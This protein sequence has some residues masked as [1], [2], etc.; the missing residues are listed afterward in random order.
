MRDKIVK[1]EDLQKNENEINI[2]EKEITLF[3]AKVV[4][5]I[6]RTIDQKV[7]LIGFHGQTIFHNSLKKFLNNWRW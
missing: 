3:H 4:S 2:F 1:L 7:D 6:L 5:K